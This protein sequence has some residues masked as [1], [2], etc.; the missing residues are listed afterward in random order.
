[1]PETARVN[2]DEAGRHAQLAR[3]R[4]DATL[5]PVPLD[6]SRHAHAD[7]DMQRR[8]YAVRRWVLLRMWSHRR[9]LRVWMLE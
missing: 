4:H 2:A 1:M 9:R 8:E 3:E 5:V 6:A 7:P